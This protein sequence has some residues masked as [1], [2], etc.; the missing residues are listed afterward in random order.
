MMF[1]RFKWLLCSCYELFL[2]API[3][4]IGGVIKAIRTNADMTYI[5]G[6]AVVAILAVVITLFAIAMPKFNKVQKID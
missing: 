4:G 3:I 6:V 1:N 5:I 2:Y